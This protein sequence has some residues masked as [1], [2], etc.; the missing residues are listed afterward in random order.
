MSISITPEAITEVKRL[1][2]K[3]LYLR[4]GISGGGCSGFSYLLGFDN[5]K[6]DV[7]DKEIDIEGVKVLV[8]HKSMLFLDGI[9][10]DFV[11]QEMMAG[12]V[13]NNPNAVSK[14]G[15]GSSFGV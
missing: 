1:Q 8:D 7:A 14:C 10:L 6:D 9:E 3:S 5:E 11:T 12:F 15:C 13:F 4:I 2:N